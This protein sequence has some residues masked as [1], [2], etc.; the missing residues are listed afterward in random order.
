MPPASLRKGPLGRLP[1]KTRGSLRVHQHPHP[2][3]PTTPHRPHPQWPN[4]T[5]AWSSSVASNTLGCERYGKGSST[6]LLLSFVAGL[7]LANTV[8]ASAS[9]FG[10][11]RVLRYR[12]VTITLAGVT[13]AFSVFVGVR[14]IIGS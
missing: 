3:A 9:T 4:P 7:I 6:G 14:L 12:F 5:T 8:V 2:G 11:H 1:R 13:A 10:F